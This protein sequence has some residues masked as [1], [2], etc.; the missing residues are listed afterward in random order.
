MKTLLNA[1]LA[2]VLLTAPVPIEAAGPGSG[3][4]LSAGWR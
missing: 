2:T 3:Q 1:I 4:P